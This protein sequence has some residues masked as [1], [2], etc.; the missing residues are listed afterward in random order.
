VG[1][2]NTTRSVKRGHRFPAEYRGAV[3]VVASSELPKVRY[4]GWLCSVRIVFVEI[5]VTVLVDKGIYS[6]SQYNSSQ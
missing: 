3:A 4:V 2:E 5:E 1:K 6:T